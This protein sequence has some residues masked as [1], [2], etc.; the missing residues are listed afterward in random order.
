MIYKYVLHITPEKGGLIDIVPDNDES[1]RP[2]R[3]DDGKLKLINAER[4]EGQYGSYYTTKTDGNP[5]W[6]FIKDIISKLSPELKETLEK[7]L[8]RQ[9]DV[10]AGKCHKTTPLLHSLLQQRSKS[11]TNWWS[12]VDKIASTAIAE[13]ESKW[14][15]GITSVRNKVILPAGNVFNFS[16]VDIDDKGNMYTHISFLAGDKDVTVNKDDEHKGNEANVGH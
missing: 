7:T 1:K 12:S 5:I 16:G 6:L 15:A 8:K 14:K 13:Y 4:P 2:E 9:E 3:G 11:L 10:W